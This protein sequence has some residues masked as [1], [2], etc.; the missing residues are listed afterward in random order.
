MAFNFKIFVAK[1]HK[2]LKISKNIFNIFNSGIVSFKLKPK[3]TILVIKIPKISKWLCT[4][5]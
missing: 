4:N 5:I 3:I 1:Y 2:I